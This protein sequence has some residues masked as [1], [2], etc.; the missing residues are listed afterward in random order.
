VSECVGCACMPAMMGSRE[1]GQITSATEVLQ[2][3]LVVVLKYYKT[4]NQWYYSPK[5]KKCVGCAVIFFFACDDG[6]DAS[7]APNALLPA[8]RERQYL[9]S[10]TSKLST[11]SD[12]SGAP[13]ALLEEERARPNERY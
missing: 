7:G 11:C 12:A 2:N 1:H 3:K 5:K 10:C 4:S 8:A 6:C 13:N 9:Y